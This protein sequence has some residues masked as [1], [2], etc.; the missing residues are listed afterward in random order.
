MFNLSNLIKK[1]LYKLLTFVGLFLL[2][3]KIAFAEWSL[4]S[5]AL[6]SVWDIVLGLVSMVVDFFGSFLITMAG[7]IV[8]YV[9][10]FQSFA[11][12][13]VVQ[14]GWTISRD[15]ANMFFILIMLLIAFGTVL[16]IETYGWKK[17][18][19]KLVIA[20]LTINFSLIICA[21]V[22]D[23]GNTIS[24][25]FISGGNTTEELD[26]SASILSSLRA[27]TI[28]QLRNNVSGE[29]PVT[30]LIMASI[31][32]LIMYI[33]IAFVLLAYAGVMISRLI[34]LWILIIVSPLAWVSSAMPGI[35]GVSGLS[36]HFGEW[37][38]KFFDLAVFFP[39]SISFFL[40]LGLIAGSTFNSLK[41]ESIQAISGS[42]FE[43]IQAAGGFWE[44][45]FPSTGFSVIMQ[46]ILVIGILWYGLGQAQKSGTMGGKLVVGWAEG[47]KKWVEGKAKTAMKAAPRTIGGAIYTGADKLSKGRL[48]TGFSQFK[49]SQLDKLEKKA[50]IGRMLGGAGTRF[51]AQQKELGDAAGKSAKLRPNDIEERL[52]QTAFTPEGMAER[53]GMIKNLIDKGQ[54]SLDQKPEFKDQWLSMLQT[55]QNSGGNVVDLIK[56]RPDLALNENVQKMIGKDANAPQVKDK[57]NEISTKKTPEDKELA[58]HKILNEDIFKTAADIAGIQKESFDTKGKLKD[59]ELIQYNDIASRPGGIDE[60]KTKRETEA[61]KSD[62]EIKKLESQLTEARKQ[63]NG[64]EIT[65]L[66]SL[67]EGMA[68]AE[69]NM[70]E[71]YNRDMK[72]LMTEQISI[73]GKTGQ[74]MLLDFLTKQAEKDGTLTT[75]NLN[76]LASKNKAAHLELMKYLSIMAPGMKGK[77]KESIHKQVITNETLN[78]MPDPSAAP[79]AG[80]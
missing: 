12:V 51:A 37:W 15:L 72:T 80:P 43:S 7:S 47:T 27:G 61:E 79:P 38:K 11:T 67:I 69:K 50:V 2:V 25:F 4:V 62:K 21:S 57:W 53:A 36:N 71:N 13:P 10:S 30:S 54:F 32:Q 9:F 44:T 40:M 66:E 6:D 65:R 63:D 55:F 60:L 8:N 31:G 68:S 76:S 46:F 23:F 58:I 42:N 52:K 24:R 16:R 19:P 39:V 28:A 29:S 75:G 64:S 77:W 74:K 73:S 56:K 34:K 35:K 41:Q 26:V 33:V 5:L 49:A 22:I 17:L 70:M 78:T 20:A 14:I 1:H 3:P 45:L 18:I 48:D 59:S